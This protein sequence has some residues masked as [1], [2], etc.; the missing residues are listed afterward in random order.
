MSRPFAVFTALASTAVFGGVWVA[1][2]PAAN[3][4]T[5]AEAVPAAAAPAAVETVYY[6]GCRAARAAGAAPLNRDEPGYRVEM[7]G[8]GDGVACEDYAESGGSNHASR[9]WMRRRRR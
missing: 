3:S 8:D 7:D 2:G 4:A 1:T 5:A 6:S 9:G